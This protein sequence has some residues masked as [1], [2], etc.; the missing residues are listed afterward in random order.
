MGDN[1][2]CIVPVQC[3]D[4][5]EVCGLS[6]PLLYGS[7]GEDKQHWEHLA[8]AAPSQAELAK[9]GKLSDMLSY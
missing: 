6:Y 4:P 2:G 1:Q 9:A 3:V 5:D 8:L 7:F